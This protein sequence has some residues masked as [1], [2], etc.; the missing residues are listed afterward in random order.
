MPI[1]QRLHTLLKLL[2]ELTPI[3]L[4]LG[5]DKQRS[6]QIDVLDVQPTA[7]TGEQIARAKPCPDGD[8]PGGSGDAL[9]DVVWS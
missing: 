5:M 8:G 9:P 3:A 1:E 7:V 4:V 6:K 2:A